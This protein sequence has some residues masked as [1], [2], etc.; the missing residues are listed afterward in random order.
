MKLKTKFLICIL[1]VLL[2]AMLSGCAAVTT[3]YTKNDE[4]NYTVSV[5]YD[6][7]GGVFT[8]NTSVITDSYN[9][10]QIEKNSSGEAEIALISPDN[11][12]RGTDAFSAV[13]S[14]YFLAGW[15]KECTE[16]EDADGNKTY[17]YSSKWDFEKDILK[18]DAGKTYNSQEP[19]LTLYAAWV[20][21]FEIEFYDLD[22]GELVDELKFDPTVK[23][24]FE[25][26]YWSEET[27]SIEMNDFPK[28]D[29][30]TFNAA[31]LGEDGVDMLT[32]LKE[33][34]IKHPGVVNF[35]TGTAENPVMKL[36]VDY[37]EGE[38]YRIYSAEQFAESAN[39]SGNYEIFADLDFS[40]EIWP[41]SFMYGN[42]TGTIKGNGHTIKNVELIQT[43]NS[44]VNAGLFGYL[45]ETASVSDLKLEN[46]TFT[47]KSGTRV[48]GTSYGL[49][50][51]TLSADAD[52]KNVSITDSTLQIDSSCYF[53]VDDY[54][55]GLTCGM[56]DSTVFENAE[57]ECKAVG[58]NPETVK[59]NVNGN[60]VTLEFVNE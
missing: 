39:L 42:F 32:A 2:I 17:S 57:V 13:K 43:N 24:D 5:K 59:V 36:Y 51:G 48:V 22:T 56:G 26:P 41:T 50:A 4:D 45:T 54:S 21:L 10:E 37:I 44:K 9:L 40:D 16:S 20:P 33:T 29:G 23:S 55:I 60:E 30:Y 47:V 6:A 12:A 31:Y 49:V 38:W 35:E 18:V 52:V 25:L 14:G 53:G 3:P 27:G 1:S 46:I 7:N 11:S 28:R 19:V 15:Y 58:D 8:T 34:T